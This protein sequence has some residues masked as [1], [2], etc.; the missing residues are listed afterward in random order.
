MHQQGRARPPVI[1]AMGRD[2]GD[3]DAGPGP[4]SVNHPAAVRSGGGWLTTSIMTCATAAL[5]SD[6]SADPRTSGHHRA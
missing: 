4:R 5:H 2:R 6:V 1:K 3:K